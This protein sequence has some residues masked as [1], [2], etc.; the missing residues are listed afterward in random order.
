MLN[1]ISESESES[2]FYLVLVNVDTVIGTCVQ[3]HFRHLKRSHLSSFV[4]LFTMLFDGH[5][6][7][8]SVTCYTSCTFVTIL[9]CNILY[10][11]HMDK[12]FQCTLAIPY[13]THLLLQIL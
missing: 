8:S 9:F 7:N 1:K 2:D 12:C 13:S 11:N 6:V 10:E 4:V 3:K 5:S